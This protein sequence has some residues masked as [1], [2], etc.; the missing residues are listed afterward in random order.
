MTAP[1]WPR[2]F[3]V[4]EAVFVGDTDLDTSLHSQSDDDDVKENEISKQQS[5]QNIKDIT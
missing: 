3:T 2:L 1:K 5:V 4:E